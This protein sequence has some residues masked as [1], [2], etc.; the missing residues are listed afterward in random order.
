MKMSRQSGQVLLALVVA[1][2]LTF[3]LEAQL[4]VGFYKKSCPTAEQIVRE[5]V[6][7]AFRNDEGI[8]ADFVRMYF[9]DCF[10]RVSV[11]SSV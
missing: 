10:V 7:K 3:P 9:H 8:L 1:F 5:E 6:I 2:C 11:L 4:K